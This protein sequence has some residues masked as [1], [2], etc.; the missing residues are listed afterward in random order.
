[1]PK[2]SGKSPLAEAIRYALIRMPKTRP[3][4]DNGFLELDNN[5]VERSVKTVALGRKNW[6]F[7]GSERDGK[8]MAIATH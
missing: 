1:M 5:I 4:L 6:M 2:I 7:A 8:A 3:Y